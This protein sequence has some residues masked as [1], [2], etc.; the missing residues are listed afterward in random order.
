MEPGEG[1]HKIFDYIKLNSIIYRDFNVCIYGLDSDLIFLSLINK[2]KCTNIILLREKH[3]IGDELIKEEHRTSKYIYLN[4]NILYDLLIEFMDPVNLNYNAII[5]YVFICFFLGNDFLPA[6]PSLNIKDNGL[7][8]ILNIYKKTYKGEYLI[9]LNNEMNNEINNE[10]MNEFIKSLAEIED[11]TLLKISIARKARISKFNKKIKYMSPEA[12]KIEESKYVEWIM[13]DIIFYTIDNW[14]S[15]YYKYYFNIAKMNK[16]II[17]DY[18]TGMIWNLNYYLGIDCY[19]KWTWHYSFL[20][21][22]PIS[23]FINVNFIINKNYTKFIGPENY[24]TQLLYILPNTS[25]HLLPEKVQKKFQNLTDFELH[26]I[27]PKEVKIDTMN[28]RYLHEANVILPDNFNI[29]KNII[30]VDDYL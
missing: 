22:P 25:Y 18:I 17:N 11:E 2:I 8:I 24:I 19:N 13:P 27:Y 23:D 7:D 14:K 4:I 26:Y 30:C 28:K 21:A 1:E 16:I 10:F 12:R 15:R 5:D 3:L 29:I 6:I 20:A 9:K